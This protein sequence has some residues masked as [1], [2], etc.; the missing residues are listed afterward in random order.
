MVKIHVIFD[1]KTKSEWQ[2]FGEKISNEK[3]ILG[4]MPLLRITMNENI[5]TFN[6]VIEYAYTNCLGSDSMCCF[7][8]LITQSK[9]LL[10][11]LN[12]ILKT[13]HFEKNNYIVDKYGYH[14]DMTIDELIERELS[15]KK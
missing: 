4:H 9:T 3:E 7:T 10:K 8:T 15:N 2:M 13:N 12:T 14:Y 6:D 1:F 5:K 11:K